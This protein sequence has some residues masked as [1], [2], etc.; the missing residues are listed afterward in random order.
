VA[1]PLGTVEFAAKSNAA[2]RATGTGPNALAAGQRLS[3]VRRSCCNRLDVLTHYYP[4]ATPNDLSNNPKL[5]E[6]DY[7]VLA[8]RKR[9]AAAETFWFDDTGDAVPDSHT[10]QITWDYDAAGRLTD[11][12]FNHYDDLLDQTQGFTYD[13][14]G[15]RISRSLDNGNN[16]TIDAVFAS[17]YDAN[18]RLLAEQADVDNN[19]TVDRTT[20]FGYTGTQQTSKQVFDNSTSVVTQSTTYGYNLQGRMSQAVVNSYDAAGALARSQ[21]L[22]YEYDPA[23]IRVAQ[24]GGHAVRRRRRETPV[25]TTP[26]PCPRSFATCAWHTVT[27]LKCHPAVLSPALSPSAGPAAESRRRAREEPRT[28]QPPVASGDRAV[29]SMTK[30]KSPDQS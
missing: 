5:A 29:C 8:D 22:S 24:Q 2:Q 13:L 12:V 18:D 9:T 27:S 19:G 26:L 10:N 28:D 23:G 4:D 17:L 6:F 14:T 16:A 15:N 7:T 20:D 30:S 21:T 25:P 1:R 3:S 11:E